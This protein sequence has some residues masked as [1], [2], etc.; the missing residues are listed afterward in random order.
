MVTLARALGTVSN[1]HPTKLRPVLYDVVDIDSL[2]R[3]AG[4]EETSVYAAFNYG[5]YEVVVDGGEI[6]LYESG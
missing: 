1:V 6:R 3:L 2:Q 4:H 5:K